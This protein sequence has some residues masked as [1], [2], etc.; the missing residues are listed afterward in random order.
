M[1]ANGMEAPTTHQQL[2]CIVNRWLMD[3]YFFLAVDAMRN[4][5]YADF[6]GVRDVLERLLSRPL[7]CTEVMPSK[8]RVL[9]FLSRINDGEK[10]D[11]A[12][13]SDDSVTP[14]ESAMD[15]LIT[16]K[17]VFSIS[18]EDLEKVCTSIRE[19]LVVIC[20]KNGQFEKAKEILTKHFPCG[21]VG[22]KAL[23]MGLANQ[24][25]KS[26]EILE[27]TNFKKFKEDMVNFSM[28]LFPSSVPFLYKAAKQLVD[29]RLVDVGGASDRRGSQVEDEA[30][31]TDISRDSV[32]V[33]LISGGP[34]GRCVPYGARLSPVDPGP[35]SCVAGQR[36]ENGHAALAWRSKPWQAHTV[37]RLVTEPDSQVDTLVYTGPGGPDAG[38]ELRAAP[39]MPRSESTNKKNRTVWQ[40]SQ[41]PPTSSQEGP[42]HGSCT[43]RKVVVVAAAWEDSDSELLESPVRRPRKR[44]K[45]MAAAR[46]DNDDANKESHSVMDSSSSTPQ[47]TSP[48]EDK[49]KGKLL[50]NAKESKEL[51]SDEESLFSDKGQKTPTNSGNSKKPWSK[52]ESRTLKEAVARFGEGN[53]AKIMARCK[54]D[55]R[56]NVNLK[57][58]WRTMKRLKLV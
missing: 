1:A 55:N 35:G 4:D 54:F 39:G 32:P 21:M 41:Y 56:T 49:T 22:K 5:K 12:F 24:K 19:M 28:Q 42:G 3:Y 9:Q 37:A 27:Q 33:C 40:A 53:W 2:E 52:E 25:V 57:D 51:W 18:D 29:M 31:L 38:P 36:P 45:S 26:H 23:L 30:D 15:V 50:D 13:E 6:C 17:E 8:I 16:L 43:P 46:L 14:L 11:L 7:E 34:S 20:L 47:K 10:L 58:R 48:K 44:G